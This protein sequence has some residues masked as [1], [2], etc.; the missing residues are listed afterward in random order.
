MTEEERITAINAN[1]SKVL[2]KWLVELE[3]EIVNGDDLLANLH[4]LNIVAILYGYNV[5]SMIEDSRQAAYNLQ[6]LMESNGEFEGFS[7][8]IPVEKQRILCPNKDEHGN[9]PLHNLHC[10]YPDCEKPS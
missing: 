10:T 2:E 8:L 1:A 6:K 7:E 5:Y 3:G 9:C 4:A